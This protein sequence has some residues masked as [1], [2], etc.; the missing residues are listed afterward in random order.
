MIKN[1]YG[2]LVMRRQ[3]RLCHSGEL[4]KWHKGEQIVCRDVGD[5]CM[6]RCISKWEYYWNGTEWQ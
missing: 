2:F 3:D 1:C 4:T 6:W 5:K